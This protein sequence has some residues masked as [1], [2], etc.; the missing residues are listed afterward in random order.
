MEY[1]PRGRIAYLI[2]CFLP[3]GGDGNHDVIVAATGAG[4]FWHI[5]FDLISEPTPE[6]RSR[7]RRDEISGASGSGARFSR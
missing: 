6:K 5:H 1:W 2:Q 4:I 3:K 7:D